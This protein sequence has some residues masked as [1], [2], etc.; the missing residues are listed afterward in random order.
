[1]EWF[2]MTLRYK[3]VNMLMI[4]V[5]LDEWHNVHFDQTTWHV[6]I[7]HI[8]HSWT[9]AYLSVSI[10][11]QSNIRL[12]DRIIIVQHAII[13]AVW[14]C[15]HCHWDHV[16]MCLIMVSYCVYLTTSSHSISLH[17]IQIF[18]IA[19]NELVISL[20]CWNCKLAQCYDQ[21]AHADERHHLW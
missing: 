1:M 7:D 14:C 19:L 13:M 16:G 9:I 5:G 12:Y 11:C 2:T 3:L 18:E 10:Q 17:H 15:D 20:V 6:S 21:L 8:A 4:I